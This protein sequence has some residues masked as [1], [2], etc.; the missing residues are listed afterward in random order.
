MKK[1]KNIFNFNLSDLLIL[2]KIKSYFKKDY[3]LSANLES[4]TNQELESDIVYKVY[5]QFLNGHQGFSFILNSDNNL[6]YILQNLARESDYKE[7]EID[8]LKV[9]GSCSGTSS[10]AK[11]LATFSSELKILDKSGPQKYAGSN[12]YFQ[13]YQDF[14]YNISALESRYATNPITVIHLGWNDRYFITGSDKSHTI[15]AIF[16]QA[17]EQTL[18]YNLK[19]VLKGIDINSQFFYQLKDGWLCYIAKHDEQFM[20]ILGRLL[21]GWLSPGSLALN[22]FP[23]SDN[24]VIIFLKKTFLTRLILGKRLEDL[25]LENKLID[26]VSLLSDKKDGH[27]VVS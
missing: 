13:D 25:K 8:I 19:C 18:T 24:H 6:S 5:T 22:V 9:F 20:F 1:F 15:A 14:L 23:L 3:P 10:P 21:T 7:S 17:K 26:F 11:D 4:L 27:G 16:R 12:I 2:L